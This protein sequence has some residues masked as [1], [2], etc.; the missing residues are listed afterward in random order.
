MS[1]RVC[2]LG[3]PSWRPVRDGEHSSSRD[4]ATVGPGAV[5]GTRSCQDRDN[6]VRV[7]VCVVWE[8]RPIYDRKVVSVDPLN[9]VRPVSCGTPLEG[10]GPVN[11]SLVRPFVQVPGPGVSWVTSAPAIQVTIP[12]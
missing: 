11:I 3:L 2:V 8:D 5:N 12:W 4:K 9:D 1:W 6:P 10:P 7:G